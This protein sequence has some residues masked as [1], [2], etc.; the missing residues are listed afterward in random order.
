LGLTSREKFFIKEGL[1]R[2]IYNISI[3]HETIAFHALY[4]PKV[5]HK[6][7]LRRELIVP[8]CGRNK[9]ICP[10]T[11]DSHVRDVW[12]IARECFKRHSPFKVGHRSLIVAVHSMFYRE[13]PP[14]LRDA[15]LHAQSPFFVHNGAVQSFSTSILL[16]DK[17]YALKDFN[18][19]CV[20]ADAV[21]P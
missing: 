14:G 17:W 11:K 21:S 6:L 5:G 20:T 2:I 3:A 4:L 16:G 8:S 10:T 18:S 1:R 12:F 9:Y 7:Q 15:Q 13:L 19:L